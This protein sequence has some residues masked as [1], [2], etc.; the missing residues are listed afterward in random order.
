MYVLF[1]LC[2]LFL[3]I[4]LISKIWSQKRYRGSRDWRQRNPGRFGGN[5]GRAGSD[6]RRSGKVQGN[7]GK[8][9]G[10]SDCEIQGTYRK[11]QGAWKQGDMREVKVDFGKR[12]RSVIEGTGK[13]GKIHKNPGEKEE[14]RGKIWKR[15]RSRKDIGKK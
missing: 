3:D 5:R 9:Q 12:Q 1:L 4:P 8:K 14:E 13:P 6:A 11:I 2:V 10:D 15:C 7:V